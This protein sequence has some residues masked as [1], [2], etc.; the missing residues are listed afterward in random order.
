MTFKNEEI[1]SNKTYNWLPGQNK[2]PKQKKFWLDDMKINSDYMFII[3]EV[4]TVYLKM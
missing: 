4:Y 2:R 1:Y 3:Y